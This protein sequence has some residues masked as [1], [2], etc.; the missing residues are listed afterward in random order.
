MARS[1][2]REARDL[3]EAALRLTQ[4]VRDA[5]FRKQMP[6]DVSYPLEDAEAEA[7]NIL[8]KTVGA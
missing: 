8:A 3:A 7:K 2:D 4:A 6:S 5:F 1:F